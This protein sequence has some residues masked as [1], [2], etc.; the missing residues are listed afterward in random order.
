VTTPGIVSRD[1]IFVRKFSL[2]PGKIWFVSTYELTEPRSEQFS[3]GFDPTDAAAC[4]AY[5]LSK[6]S[7]ANFT[8][9]I[10]AAAA[11][12]KSDHWDVASH[13]LI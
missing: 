13:N 6:G 1:N 7:F 8:N 12:W 10:S 11:I 9:P 4:C 3:D 2:T 5:I